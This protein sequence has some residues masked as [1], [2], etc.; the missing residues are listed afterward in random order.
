MDLLN[1]AFKCENILAHYDCVVELF[2]KELKF[3]EDP[4]SLPSGT[5]TSVMGDY[6]TNTT[7][8][9]RI[10]EERCKFMKNALGMPGTCYGTQKP[11]AI[12][13]DVYPPTSGVV[14]LNTVILPNYK[15]QGQYYTTQLNLKAIPTSTSHVFHH[16]EFKR[17]PTKNSAPLS[18]DSVAID[19]N[20][21][22]EVIAFFTDITSDIVMPTGFTPNGDSNNDVFKPQGSALHVTEYEFRIWNRWGQEVFRSTDPLKGWDGYY[23]SRIAQTGVYAYVITYKNVYNE[24]KVLKGNVTLLR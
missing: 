10:I 17:H 1:G 22:E 11:Y 8:L 5:F 19:F 4:V 2:S 18:L 14:K 24:P 9:R 15:C 16:W 12:S 23:E 7:R 13:V 3:H 20:Q 21:D 6:D